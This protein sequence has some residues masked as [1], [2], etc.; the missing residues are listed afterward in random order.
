MSELNETTEKKGNGAYLAIILLLLIGLGA[1]AF[2]WSKKNRELNDCGNENTTLKADM[3]GMNQMMSGYV[4]NMSSDLKADFK[5]MLK[6]YDALI[7]KDKTKADSLNL[8]KDKIQSLINEIDR[9]KKMSASQLF[10]MRKENETLRGIM[11]S[12]VVQIDSLNTLNLKLTSDLDQT[13]TKLNSTSE[14]RDMFKADAEQKTAQVKKGSR[15]QAYGFSSVG[16]KMKLNNT[17]DETNRAR[18]VVQIKSSFTVSEN[19]ITD[20]GKKVVY[21]QVINPD[22]KTLQTKSSNSIQTELGNIAYSDKKEIDYQNERIDLSIY[23]DIRGEEVLK[24][25]YKVKIYCEGNLIGT[26]SFTLK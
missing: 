22:G 16:L 1:M 12:Y 17:A 21:M 23:Y 6:T 25:N 8:Q 24:G 14:E 2:L 19:P 4:D 20:A 11:K 26:D 9:N 3:D 5:N 10:Q 15:L 13:T 18:N 7:A